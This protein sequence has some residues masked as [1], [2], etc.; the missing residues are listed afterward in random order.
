RSIHISHNL[1]IRPLE[2][3]G[4]A[5]AT[6]RALGAHA[7]GLRTCRPRGLQEILAPPGSLREALARGRSPPLGVVEQFVGLRPQTGEAP[8]RGELRESTRAEFVRGHLGSEVPEPL[9]W[10]QGLVPA[11]VQDSGLLASALQ[12]L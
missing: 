2:T 10:V 4:E 11:S 5:R 9:F 12:E 7:S 6:D 1:P 3:D 8:F